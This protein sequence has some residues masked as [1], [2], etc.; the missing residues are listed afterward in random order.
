MPISRTLLMWRLLAIISVLLIWAGSLLP[1]EDIARVSTALQ[2]KLL[3]FLGYLLVALL[4]GQ[5][6]RQLSWWVVWLLTFLIGAG[7]EVAQ[8]LLTRSRTFE[9]LDFVAN[10]GGALAG[11]AVSQLIQLTFTDKSAGGGQI[12]DQH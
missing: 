11:V 6:W 7:A 8:E 9:W 10:G 5:G 3:H 4:I 1:A 12:D 2:D